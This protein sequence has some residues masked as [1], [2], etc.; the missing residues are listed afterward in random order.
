MYTAVDLSK[1]IVNKCVADGHPISNLQLQK[2]L[3]YIQVEFLKQG[4]TAFT[5]QIEAWQFGP[6]VPNAYYY[7]CGFGAMRIT[8][9]YDGAAQPL[10]EDIDSI[11]NIVQEKSTMNPWQVVADTHRPGGAWKSI[12]RDGEGN[13]QVIPLAVMRKLG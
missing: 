6:V 3:Y 9:Q 4:K 5:D 1:Y 11:D 2:I 12:Y 8:E 7:F 13:H 10:A